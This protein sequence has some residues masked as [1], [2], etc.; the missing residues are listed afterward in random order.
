MHY[1]WALGPNHYDVLDLQ[2]STFT[3]KQLRT[4]FRKASLQYHPDK[5]GEA[6]ADI[7]VKIRAAHEVLVDPILRVA[8]DRFGPG[9]TGCQTC[10]TTKDYIKY[11][12]NDYKTFYGGLYV[13]LFLLGMV[14]NAGFG[15]YWRYVALTYM[16]AWE[17]SMLIGPKRAS[18]VSCAFPHRTTYEQ[19][20][21]ARQIFVSVFLAVN[22]IRPLVLP[23]TAE[24]MANI[25]DAI[26]KIS[27]LNDQ[28]VAS[29]A[30]QL[31][32]S[33]DV[34]R[35]D[36]ECMTQLKRQMRGVIVDSL[37]AA[38]QPVFDDARMAVYKR[39][40][41]PPKQEYYDERKSQL[42]NI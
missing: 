35:D 16:A 9:I 3:Q 1:E 21:I 17:F 12:I 6:G 29:S 30:E 39:I 19:L 38:N 25:K 7:F 27:E 24:K 41:D 18:V 4:N 36:A 20:R 15:K 14:G 13:I 8:Y 22:L 2:F 28:I 42:E 33:L 26:K 5:I 23:S 31:Q 37:I 32:Q 11:G 40:N 10:K 34:F